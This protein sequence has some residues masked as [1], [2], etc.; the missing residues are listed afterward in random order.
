MLKYAL[1]VVV[2]MTLL[3]CQR[4]TVD[5]QAHLSV[6]LA[7]T[8]TIDFLSVTGTQGDVEL[9]P[10]NTD[11]LAATF[12]VQAGVPVTLDAT[13]F[14]LETDALVG[15]E[16]THT[17]TPVPGEQSVTIDVA[18]LELTPV[19]GGVF[20]DGRAFSGTL[21]VTVR[22]QGTGYEAVAAFQLGEAFQLPAGR[23]LELVVQNPSTGADVVTVVTPQADTPVVINLGDA[24]E[25]PSGTVFT[26]GVGIDT[27]HLIADPAF[28][29]EC[30]YQLSSTCDG[31]GK[32]CPDIEPT[33]WVPCD[34]DLS[35]L[36]LLSGSSA[37]LEGCYALAMRYAEV[38]ESCTLVSSQYDFTPPD[39][40]LTV[41]PGEIAPTRAQEVTVTVHSNK[42]LLP[43]SLAISQTGADDGAST[44]CNDITAAADGLTFTCANLAW[45]GAPG[46]RIIQVTGKDLAGNAFA[47]TKPIQDLSGF[48]PA[49]TGPELRVSSVEPYPAIPNPASDHILLSVEFINVGSAVDPQKARACNT[50]LSKT[51]VTQKDGPAD[52]LINRE[53]LPG[54]I[55]AGQIEQVWMALSPGP[56]GRFD[57]YP[58]GT[59]VLSFDLDWTSCE[60]EPEQS[61]SFSFSVDLQFAALPLRWLSNDTLH[62]PAQMGLNTIE[63]SDEPVQM[64]SYFILPVRGTRTSLYDSSGPTVVSDDPSL[65]TA[66][67]HGELN[68]QAPGHT[69][70]TLEEPAGTPHDSVEV[71]L[72]PSPDLLSL[73][74]N[75]LTRTNPLTGDS[76][77]VA[78]D[79]AV[80]TPLRVLWD[81]TRDQALIVG[82]QG[83]QVESGVV[84]PFVP[85]NA[86]TILD[87]ELTAAGVGH[88]RNAHDLALLINRGGA[89]LHCEVDLDTYTTAME[90]TM[91]DTCPTAQLVTHPINGEF[92]AF[93]ANPQ[94]T[95]CAVRYH[96][97][98]GSFALLDEE[99][100]GPPVGMAQKADIDPW[101]NVAT[102]VAVDPNQSVASAVGWRLG[103]GL[104]P[105]EV[106][107]DAIGPIDSPGQPYPVQMLMDPINNQP[108]LITHQEPNLGGI[109][110]QRE[111]GRYSTPTGQNET[112]VSTAYTSTEAGGIDLPATTAA[113]LDISRDIIYLGDEN[114]QVMAASIANLFSTFHWNAPMLGEPTGRPVIDLALAGPEPMR[115]TQ[116]VGKAYQTRTILGR[117]FAPS[118][119][120][121]F[122]QGIEAAIVSESATAITF[123]IPAA[124][125]HLDREIFGAWVTVLTHGVMS[126]PAAADLEIPVTPIGFSTD[127]TE[128]FSDYCSD[129]TRV[130]LLP[131]PQ[132]LG[133]VAT[134]VGVFHLSF[135][136]FDGE[137]YTDL[138]APA[139]AVTLNGFKRMIG[140]VE[141]REVEGFEW[142][143]LRLAEREDGVSELPVSYGTA[144]PGPVAATPAEDVIAL[145]SGDEVSFYW[146]SS[147][148]LHP[149][150]RA[151]GLFEG[152]SNVAALAFMTNGRIL[153]AVD[154]SGTVAALDLSS[155]APASL[156]VTTDTALCSGVG[157][158][159]LVELSP[160]GPNG[161]ATAVLWH[162]NRAS[163]WSIEHD[164]N[165]VR[166]RCVGV[167]SSM[168]HDAGRP[169]AVSVFPSGYFV[170]M[171]TQ[172][173]G[174]TTLTMVRR[175]SPGVAVMVEPLSAF[176]FDMT[177]SPNGQS[178][179]AASPTAV[180]RLWL[181]PTP[182]QA[183][184]L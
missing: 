127:G 22:D 122:V 52:F 98:S 85:C 57:T 136:G 158:G 90:G 101:G 88:R 123:E 153:L 105:T 102:V 14:D 81:P 181:Y 177:F 160:H 8:S 95:S 178:L 58:D 135:W 41:L 97:R 70:L 94:S 132:G 56:S 130:M 103:Q 6:A 134:D 20:A 159:V 121:V 162:S 60:D 139:T 179:Y 129:C 59:Y 69:I 45:T 18:L 89:Q 169:P 63:R 99:L 19:E 32:T 26:S 126:G 74:A 154:V 43:S 113:L 108:L 61:F 50:S 184:G 165:S 5:V 175:D 144:T 65:I 104:S 29:L 9:A 72:H 83:V 62:L 114:G 120:R 1:P 80:G 13:L 38:G 171:A 40:K 12:T 49:G 24:P 182:L 167:S 3:A 71:T 137:F 183:Q 84:E 30:A 110:E 17:F 96:T 168:P 106:Y 107:P 149:W 145:A 155:G 109:P 16:G 128:S 148:E 79:Q 147:L 141:S 7:Q 25:L 151:T 117:N 55:E 10:T 39:V 28:T 23:T 33:A 82:S 36:S 142:Q 86:D 173:L 75:A 115:V 67:A 51:T 76:S 64:Q 44:S 164:G 4:Q 21:P 91:P 111:I 131:A 156:T 163:V 172:S 73:T 143:E 66:N 100:D 125:Q 42:P 174:S 15:Y 68:A 161:Q 138:D 87:A 118:G 112:R 119:N 77:A 180:D 116:P 31:A 157:A 93:G 140:P 47:I 166:S 150:E 37:R 54:E 2:G 124:F 152:A 133:F 35:L 53:E 27:T 48:V 11:A 170:G 176:P 46:T 92:T 146:A 78:I 34:S